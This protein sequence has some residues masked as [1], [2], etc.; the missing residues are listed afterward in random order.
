MLSSHGLRAFAA[1]VAARLA[2]FVVLEVCLWSMGVTPDLLPPSVVLAVM[3]A[4]ALITLIPI[5][6]GGVG[7]A[8]V[9]FIGMLSAVAGEGLTGQITAAI[10][11]FRAAQWLV[12]IPIGWVLLVIMRGSHWRE[13]GQASGAVTTDAAGFRTAS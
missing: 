13:I 1:A 4:V 11:I 9:S 7:V 3:A 5:T 8:E 2:W 10:V 12:V 6:P